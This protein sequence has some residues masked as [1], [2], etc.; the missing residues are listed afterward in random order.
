MG[1]YVLSTELS[2]VK[3]LTQRDQNNIILHH[4]RKESAV[5][6]AE[7]YEDSER[8]TYKIL[9]EYHEVGCVPGEKKVTRKKTKRSKQEEETSAQILSIQKK[10]RYDHLAF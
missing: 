7:R 3:K 8:M 2:Y 5:D 9:K 10:P 1:K 4:K 6:L